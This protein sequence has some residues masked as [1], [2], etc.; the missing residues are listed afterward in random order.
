MG[1]YGLIRPFYKGRQKLNLGVL[2]PAV[3]LSI[4]GVLMIYSASN[5]NALK[6]YGDEFFFF[7]KQ[8]IGLCFGVLMLVFTYFFDYHLLLKFRYIA[9][10][11]GV[12]LLGAV[13]IPGVG[14]ENY[15]AK[16]WIGFGGFSF[17]A[18]EIAKFCF[19]VFCAGYLSKNQQKIQSFCGILPILCVGF[20]YCVLIMLEP[21]MSITMCVGV[22]M[23]VL[24][25]VGGAKIKHLIFLFIPLLLL[26]PILILIEPYRILR[27]LA[28]LDPWASPQGEG[29]QLIQSLYSLGSGG[30]FG[31]GFL[32][33]RAK[34]SF[35]PFSESDFIFSIIG[36]EFGFIGAVFVLL[37]FLV[38]IVSGYKIASKSRDRFGCFLATGI[39]T[40]IL[41]QV[42]FNVAV[43]SGLVPPT[44]LPLPFVSFGSTS[45]VVFLA[46]VGVLLNIH[47]QSRV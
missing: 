31:V 1:T 25:L 46:A 15:G 22:T 26:I 27:I 17:Q 3:V 11:V 8:L 2:V 13:F 40:I 7:N 20:L 41:V 32:N 24:L 43:V 36:E 39:T 35:L 47:R 37:V 16:R 34:Y 10:I 6:T 18:S 23:L 38:L 28:F 14:I 4:F 45:L 19:I 30:L 29:F 5:Y 33:S 44:G 42:F 12:V 9:L 21:N